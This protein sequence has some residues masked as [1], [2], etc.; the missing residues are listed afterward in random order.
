MGRE[1]VT[2]LIVLGLAAAYY[3]AADN[4][5][6]SLLSD[7]VGADGVPK[8]LAVLLGLLGAIQAARG[9]L[10]TALVDHG[11][12]EGHGLGQH[13]RSLGL[14]GVGVVYLVAAPYLGYLLATGLLVFVVAAYAGMPASPRLGVIA[15]LGSV[16][17]WLVFAKVLGVAMPGGV[18]SDLL[19]RT[20]G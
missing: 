4:I 3:F 15:V 20:A 6:R 14:I 1:L 8:V 16:V 12:A 13:L 7:A 2:G 18:L 17:L 11:S 9:A 5:P 10:R 19:A